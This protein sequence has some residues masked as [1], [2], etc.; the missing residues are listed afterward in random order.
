MA[1][2][3]PGGRGPQI[4][5]TGLEPRAT[6]T[7]PPPYHLTTS[8]KNLAPS[9]VLPAESTSGRATAFASLLPRVPSYRTLEALLAGC[10]RAEPAAQEALYARFEPLLLRVCVR[11][12]RSRAEAEDLVQEAFV[13]V[14]GRLH[15]YRGEGPLEGWVR[16]VGVTTCLD[17]Y[18]AEVRG[19]HDVGLDAAP[20]ALTAAAAD[21]PAHLAA[22]ELVAAIG[23]LPTIYRLVLNLYCIEGYSHQEIAEQ[24]GI[25]ERTSSSQLSRARRLLAE[26]LRRAETVATPTVCPPVRQ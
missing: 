2:A 14:F 24:L 12:A 13:R 15:Q 5:R 8:H 7:T 6:R 21:A 4:V 16:R 9:A 3:S 11:Y 20:A 22:D 25:E 10:L 1:E 17:H 23:R 18:R 19:W 26:Q